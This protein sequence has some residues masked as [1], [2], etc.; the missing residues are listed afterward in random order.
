MYCKLMSKSTSLRMS[1]PTSK[2]K[3]KSVCW[4][5]AVKAT[6]VENDWPFWLNVIRMNWVLTFEFVTI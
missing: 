5:S 2:A 4:P 1:K 6:T 3:T